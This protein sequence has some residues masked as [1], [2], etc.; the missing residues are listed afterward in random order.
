MNGVLGPAF[1]MDVATGAMRTVSPID[2]ETGPK[3]YNL[4]LRALDTPR[5]TYPEAV[6]IFNLTV[7]IVGAF[8]LASQFGGSDRVF[9]SL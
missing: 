5:P 1:S 9:W 6:T 7:I 8:L 4:T 3:F 2:F